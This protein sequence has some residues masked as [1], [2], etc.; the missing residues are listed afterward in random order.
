MARKLTRNSNRGRDF[1]L[2][3]I[4]GIALCFSAIW[5]TNFISREF[6][7][8]RVSNLAS[9]LATGVFIGLLLNLRQWKNLDFESKSLMMFALI[10]AF[11]VGVFALQFSRIDN[12]NEFG[13]SVAN[14]TIAMYAAFRVQRIVGSKKARR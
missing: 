3:V 6:N 9:G 4:A 10:T 1:G 5:I 12:V 2:A 7:V 11:A 8:D 13:I 14:M